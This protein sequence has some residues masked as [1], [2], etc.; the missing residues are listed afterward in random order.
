[1]FKKILIATVI[2]LVLAFIYLWFFG[3]KTGEDAPGITAPSVRTISYS[4]VN[5]YPHDTS[6]FTQ[7]LVIYKGVLYEGTGMNG[8]SKLLEVDLETGKSTRKVALDSVY[9]GE[10][11]TVLNDT[12]YQ[13]TWQNK[14]VF[15]YDLRFNKIKEF[16]L[17]TEGWGIT[18]DETNMIVSDGTDKLYF[19]NPS[20]FSLSD[21][22]SITEAGVPVFNLNELEYIDG[23]IYANQWQYPY[24]L[25]IDPA[26]ASVVA[27]IDLSDIVKRIRPDDQD[28]DKVL[29]GIAYNKETKK[30]YVTGKYWPSLFEIQLGQ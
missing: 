26:T 5:T 23:F 13:L 24:I 18:H 2:L 30:M 11:V 22:K 6:S 28:Y 1:M 3:K 20:D 9:F 10:G 4:I 8:Q 27:K 7:G 12:I 16:D 15:T 21:T 29:N 25:K 14:K 17:P 19:Y